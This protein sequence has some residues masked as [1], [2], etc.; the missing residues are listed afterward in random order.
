LVLVVHREE[1]GVGTRPIPAGIANRSL[2][3]PNASET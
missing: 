3:S 2:R 1:Q